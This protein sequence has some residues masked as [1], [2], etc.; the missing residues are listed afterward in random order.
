VKLYLKK[1][2][3]NAAASFH[4]GETNYKMAIGDFGGFTVAYRNGT[5]DQQVIA[6]SFDNDIFLPDVPQYKPKPSDTIL[7]IGAHIGTFS[8]LAASKSPKGTVH[9]IEAS[10]ET[11][12]YL[13]VNAALNPQLHVVP[14]RLAL[15]DHDGEVTLHHDRGNWGHSIMKELSPRGEKVPAMCLASFVSANKIKKI[16]FIKFNCEGAEFPILT[17][18]PDEILR[19][20]RVMLILYHLDLAPDYNLPS[21]LDRLSAVGFK[22]TVLE[23]RSTRGWIIAER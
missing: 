4:P 11:Y 17:K 7:D 14:H 8:L 22:N 23:K 3:R 15:T 13:R 19:D 20:V 5:A 9:A 16:A 1:R 6:H 12:N 10:Q 18:A 21:L 2:F